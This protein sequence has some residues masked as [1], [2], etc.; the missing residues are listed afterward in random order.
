MKTYTLKQFRDDLRRAMSEKGRSQ[1]DL[2]AD[3]G[4]HQ[5]IISNFLSERRGV[6]GESLLALWPFVYG[7]IAM[8]RP[9]ASPATPPEPER[10][11][12]DNDAE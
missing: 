11:E 12:G 5:S 6:S 2:E 8:P 7:D 10:A 3:F 1:K 9:T 4:V